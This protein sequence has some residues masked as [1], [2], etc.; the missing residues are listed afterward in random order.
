MSLCV[1]VSVCVYVYVLGV[2]EDEG[3]EHEECVCL[4]GKVQRRDFK[5]SLC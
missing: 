2:G 1:S 3:W 5:D 4:E